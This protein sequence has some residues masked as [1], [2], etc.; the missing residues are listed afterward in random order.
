MSATYLGTI[1][2]LRFSA[3]PSAFIG[4]LLLWVVLGTV[5]LVWLSLSPV[6]AMLGAL[7]A[8]LLHYLSETA[9]QLGHAWQARRTGHPMIGVQFWWLLSS[10]IYPPDEPELP[11][12]I[13][14]TRA[15]GG[16]LASLLVTVIAGVLAL[17]FFGLGGVVWYVALFFFLDNLLVFFLG[18]FLPLGFTDGSTLLRWLPK[19]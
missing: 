10:S 18:A 15:F 16:P 4:A 12:R 3:K 6:E 8:T 13:H 19:R 17:V 1:N 14:I 5:G 11:A 9:H 2:S 7:V